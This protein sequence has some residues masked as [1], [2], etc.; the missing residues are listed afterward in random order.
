[1]GNIPIKTHTHK[2]AGCCIDLILRVFSLGIKLIFLPMLAKPKDPLSLTGIKR[3]LIYGTVGI[4]N[5]VLFSSVIK[6]MR[7][8][9]PQAEIILLFL[10]KGESRNVV[11]ESSIV[12]KIIVC[13]RLNIPEK[14]RIAFRIR[15]WKP[16]LIIARFDN[17]ISYALITALSNSPYRLGQLSQSDNKN[18]FKF[19]YNIKM[20]MNLDNH[21]IDDYFYL[22]NKIGISAFGRNPYFYLRDKDL[23]AAE[24]FLS[25]NGLGNAEK[26]ITIQCGTSDHANW[27]R[28]DTGNFVSLIKLLF[29]RG[30]KPVLVGSKN[31]KGIEKIIFNQLDNDPLSAIGVLSLKETAALIKKSSL[32]V[33]HDSGLMHIAA[34]VGTKT[35]AIFGPTSTK[36]T[37]PIGPG[38]II[39]TKEFPCRP[40]YPLD[41]M[42]A[43][44]CK[45][46]VCLESL[47]PE[48][49]MDKISQTM[50]TT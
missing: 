34:A 16:D 19:L 15:K 35:I 10:N 14:S 1:M 42:K 21:E 18:Y 22:V 36:R 45:D 30:I 43:L 20:T 5:M 9:L 4:G 11:Y 17:S 33:C 39:M 28:W 27:K 31:E 3:V 12:D 2:L 38:H 26:F 6:A 47:T 7:K 8:S 23:K 46:R 48:E 13:G 41:G 49:V 25:C 37:S 24:H 44:S 32:L 29:K 50:S 40:C